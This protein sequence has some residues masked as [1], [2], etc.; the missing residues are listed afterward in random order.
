MTLH[1]TL[2]GAAIGAGLLLIGYGLR[3]P[4]RSLAEAIEALYAPPQPVLPWRQ[5]LI[6]AVT[7]PLAAAGLP[8]A[9]IRADL[10]VLDRDPTRHLATQACLAALGLFAPAAVVAVLN[11]GAATINWAAPLWACLMFGASG[12]LVA[13]ISAHEEAEA[14]RLLMRHTLS[15]LLDVVPPSLAAGA[16][17]EQALTEAAAHADGWAADRIRDALDTARRTRAPLWEPLRD[18]G[19]RTGVAQLEQ[20][21]GSLQLASGEG[22]RVREALTQRA[23]ALA[24]RLTADMEA[25]ADAATERM[26]LPLMGLAGVFLL[27]L[28]YPA[29]AGFTT[30]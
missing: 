13:D 8:R 26:S 25:A 19:A 16:G 9:R 23:A 29:I 1:L 10:A 21:A 14:R 22:A 11:S 18:L 7:A 27:F 5:R 17:V 24:E 6:T 2:I 20:L 12:F 15:A 28:I 30:T 4:R 3:P